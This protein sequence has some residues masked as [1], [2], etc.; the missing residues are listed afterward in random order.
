MRLS[1]ACASLVAAL[2]APIGVVAQPVKAPEPASLPRKVMVLPSQAPVGSGVDTSTIDVLMAS[3]FQELG[4]EV[5]DEREVATRLAGAS[6]AVEEARESYLNTDFEAAL[7]TLS[8]QREIDLANG[9]GLLAL[10]RLRD[11]EI[12]MA[13]VLVDLGRDTEAAALADGILARHPGLRLDPAEFSPAMQAVWAAAVQRCS[14]ILPPDPAPAVL[15]DLGRRAGVDW[16]ALA[17]WSPSLDEGGR[18]SVTI[19]PVTPS[20]Q[21]SRH[22]APLGPPPKWA[23]GVKALLAQRFP[24]P[25]PVA[26]GD[27]KAG[28]AAA[29]AEED[30]PWY[31]TW[32]F[33]TVVGVAVAGG[34]A[35]GVGGYYG[36]RDNERSGVDMDPGW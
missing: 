24:H 11:T 36:T 17:A 3:A 26:S 9:G 2:L 33:W 34:V 21:P 19:T 29:K 25:S 35:G 7:A 18:L 30:T 23:Q 8:A 14:G 22:A 15:A 5:V 10:P 20:K 4:F 13:Q 1:C 27:A 28:P 12:L 6:K 31:E 16:V 32:W